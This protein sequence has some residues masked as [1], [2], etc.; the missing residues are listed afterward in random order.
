MLLLTEGL[1]EQAALLGPGREAAAEA[2]EAEAVE[3]LVCEV[4]AGL[5]ATTAVALAARNRHPPR[6]DQPLETGALPCAASLPFRKLTR[7]LA[8]TMGTKVAKKVARNR[9]EDLGPFLQ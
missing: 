3:A 9:R 4:F 8:R 2:A 1:R 7:L 6:F 5:W